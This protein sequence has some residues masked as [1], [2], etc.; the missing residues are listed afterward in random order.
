MTEAKKETTVEERKAKAQEQA[1]LK[2]QAAEQA[3]EQEKQAKQAKKAEEKTALIAE[4]VAL[5]SAKFTAMQEVKAKAIA[6]LDAIPA[7]ATPEAV[8]HSL[9]QS[10]LVLKDLRELSKEIKKAV[11]KVKDAKELEGAVENATAMVMSLSE[12]IN[13]HN[14]KVSAAKKAAREAEREAKK[15]AREAERA[16]TAMPKQND[17]TRPRPETSCGRA[18]E[19]MDTLRERLGQAAPISVVLEAAQS[20]DLNHD[21]VKTQYARW[22]KF[23][24]ISGRVTLPIPKDLIS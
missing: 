20:R 12:I 11:T 22:K 7:D 13:G 2:K 4:T 15:L 24:G 23:N 21:T 5:V 18:W 6:I 14:E 1:R 10:K 17:I 9:G 19:L 3:R 16:K 8:T